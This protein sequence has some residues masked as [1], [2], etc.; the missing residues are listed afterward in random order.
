MIEAA[1]RPTIMGNRRRP[2][3]VGDAP[4][5]SWKY[6]GRNVIAPYIAN[7]TTKPIAEADEK[8]RFA[9]KCGA[10]IGSD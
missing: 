1:K 4:R 10:M 6:R 9:N 3:L 8:T 5:T 2:E 7:P